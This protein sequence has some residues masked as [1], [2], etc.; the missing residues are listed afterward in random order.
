MH[1]ASALQKAADRRAMVT[2]TASDNDG[3]NW[4]VPR[5]QSKK[6]S[7]RRVARQGMHTHKPDGDAGDHGFL[8]RG[9]LRRPFSRRTTR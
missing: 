5:P 6:R 7:K 4:A 3:D 2:N 1:A 9:V 8:A